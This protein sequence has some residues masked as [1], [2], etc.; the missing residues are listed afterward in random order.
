MTLVL[1]AGCSTDS[2]PAAP[3]NEEATTDA[4]ASTEGSTSASVSGTVPVAGNATTFVT[5]IPQN[6][7]MVPPPGAQ[8]LM[9]QIEMTFVPS[10][11]IARTGQPVTRD[12]SR[13]T[14]STTCRSSRSRK[15]RHA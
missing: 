8:P 7:S 12:W 1:I 3:A 2:G 14:V 9:D 6:P 15:G 10:V 4:P 11:L 5:L 13:H